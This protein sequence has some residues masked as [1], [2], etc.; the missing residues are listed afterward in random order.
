[1]AIVNLNKSEIKKLIKGNDEKIDEILSLFGVGVENITEKEIMV[2]VT[3]N[4]PDMLSQQGLIRALYSFLGKSKKEKYKLKKPKKDYEIK[5]DN[6]V[7]KVRPYTACAI[8]KNLNFNNEKIKEIIDIQEKLHSTIGRNR[9]KLA[10]GIYPL[11]KIKL[12]IKFEARK[13][14]QIKFIPLED[15]RELTGLQILSKHP[16]GKE[17]AHLLKNQEKFPIFI[18]SDNQILSMPPIINSEKTGKIS[19]KTKSVFIECSGFDLTLLSKV[20]N[21]IV[22]ILA[23]MGGTIYQMK[24]N[25]KGKTIITPDLTPEKIK[26]NIKEAEKLLGLNLTEKQVKVLLTKMGYEYKARKV[27]IP[28]YRIDILHPVDIY[29]D[30]AIAYGY[31]NFIPSIPEIATIGEES[32]NADFTR[33]LRNLL[34]GLG[35]LETS[36]Y[37]LTTKQY[38]FKN[39]NL[40]PQNSSTIIEVQDSKTE[41]NI[42][43]E[44]LLSNQ[45]KILSENLDSEYPQN[46][47]ELGKVFEKTNENNISE[48][49]NLCILKT[50]GNFTE[51]KQILQYIE[52]MLNIKFSIEETSHPSF[53]EGRAGKILFKGKSVGIIGEIHPQ[54]LKN[55]HLKIPIASLEICVDNLI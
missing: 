6:S 23:D 9:K 40:K 42:L 8:V 11:E 45:L 28:S 22:T 16:T 26:I 36:S 30:L 48:K 13:P 1:M 29:E 7:S 2:E 17:Y 38:Q 35:L 55:W 25:Y 37:H 47:F 24:L 4:R 50:P 21:I 33:K 5:I 14:N 39:M 44:N 43:R 15:T 53:I 41:Y 54:I 27:S 12:P 46:I 10:I 18:D 20:L 31:Q 3:P 49:T 52:D 32:T 51:I 19:E 34:T